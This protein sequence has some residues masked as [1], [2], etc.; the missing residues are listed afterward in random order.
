MEREVYLYQ[1][2]D[3]EECVR[4]F[5]TQV[6]HRP[7]RVHL[8]HHPGDAGH[9]QARR[10]PR[11]PRE[12]GARPEEFCADD[13]V[14]LMS[15]YEFPGGLMEMESEYKRHKDHHDLTAPLGA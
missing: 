15:A 3:D 9:R 5:G 6:R 12:R 2:A 1:L 14:A 10:L 13:Y 4:P 8:R 7:D 11:Q